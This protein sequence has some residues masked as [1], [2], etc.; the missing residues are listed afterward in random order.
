VAFDAATNRA[1]ITLGDPPRGDTLRLIVRGTGETP[2]LGG[3][4]GQR[5]PFAGAVG[6][7]P[8]GVHNGHD[9]ISM[10]PSG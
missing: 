6:G 2:V 3:A 10:F 9:F 4:G 7:P 1:T 5:I 8:G